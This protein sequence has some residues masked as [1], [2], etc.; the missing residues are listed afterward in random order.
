MTIKREL[1]AKAEQLIEVYLD[2]QQRI[3]DLQ[4]QQGHVV[5]AVL[6]EMPGPDEGSVTYHTNR[7]RVTA[8]R[9]MNR[10]VA[11]ADEV[12]RMDNAVDLRLYFRRKYDLNLAAYREAPAAVKTQ[13]GRV[14]TTKPAKPS[15]RVVPVE[16]Q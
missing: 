7:H 15:L 14:V 1:S 6:K 4:E 2:L 9:K 8:T 10:T 5:A 11:D 13:L 12:E 16:E 3:K